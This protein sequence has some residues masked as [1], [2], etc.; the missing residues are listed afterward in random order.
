MNFNFNNEDAKNALNRFEETCIKPLSTRVKEGKKVMN[1]N[2]KRWGH[3]EREKA[4]KSL[5][6]MKERLGYYKALHVKLTSA[7]ENSDKF[8]N[9]VL[10]I[11]L[12]W[13]DKIS[14]KGKQPREMM[15][16]QAEMMEGFM[17]KI[18]SILETLDFK[19]LK[20]RRI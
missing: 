4:Q 16:S 6:A 18:Y 3:K 20:E 9:T 5:E 17:K 11:Y 15:G 12:D 2:Y 10:G 13:Y 14:N 7:T 1:N 8:I 19:E